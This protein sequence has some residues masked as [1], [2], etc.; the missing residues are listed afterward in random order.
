MPNS[1]HRATEPEANKDHQSLM[2]D[3]SIPL[4]SG[5]DGGQ[6]VIPPRSGQAG[7]PAF[8]FGANDGPVDDF[9]DL[10]EGWED[11]TG[12]NLFSS[13]DKPS[14]TEPPETTNDVV[15]RLVGDIAEEF[16]PSQMRQLGESLIR[17]ADSLDQMWRPDEVRSS[18]HWIT[19]AGRIERQAL[20]L[21]QTAMRMRRVAQQ[22]TRHISP[23]FLGEPHWEMLLELFIQFAGGAKV[24]TKSLCI[25]SGVPDTTALRMIDRL[26]EACLVER[27]V[28]SQDRRVTLVTLTRQG[29]V[30]VG[31]ILLEAER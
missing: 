29:V 15:L 13:V 8:G 14:S 25:V 19:S 17:L 24:S 26:E 27:S 1:K 30:A 22:R 7:Q 23:E 11:A 16:S 21:A 9:L 28:S 5:Q 3:A 6:P 12:H 4:P 31:S 18:F 10:V 20:G 2:P